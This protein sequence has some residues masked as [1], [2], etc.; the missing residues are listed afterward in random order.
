MATFNI[1]TQPR[2]SGKSS[3]LKLKALEEMHQD[4]YEL[5]C[6]IGHNKHVDEMNLRWLMSIGCQFDNIIIGFKLLIDR[7]KYCN[8]KKILI[9]IDEPFLI[10]ESAQKD[11]LN[12][13]SKQAD[14]IKID[15][16]GRG[17]IEQELIL[18]K[19]YIDN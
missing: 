4:N 19:D 6:I 12:F 3:S 16:F 5:I 1:K 8:F 14:E 13:I 7:L 9:L 10:E 18:F 17:T 15:V 11:I 2:C